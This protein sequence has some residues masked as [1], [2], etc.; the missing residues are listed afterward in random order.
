MQTTVSRCQSR[1]D[2]SIG[3]VRDDFLESA[4]SWQR[5]LDHLADGSRGAAR[6]D[7]DAIGEKDRLVDVVGDH[8][9]R[10]GAAVE[11]P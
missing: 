1:S 7:R 5:N 6:H 9:D 10:L 8:Q 4:R 2:V 11:R 3:R